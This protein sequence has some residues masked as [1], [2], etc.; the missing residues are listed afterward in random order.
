[1]NRCI[2]SLL[3]LTLAYAAL[4]AT[5]H[6]GNISAEIYATAQ[7]SLGDITN[8]HLDVPTVPIPSN[9]SGIPNSISFTGGSVVSSYEMRASIEQDFFDPVI[10]FVATAEGE[11]FPGG[12]NAGSLGMSSGVH[13]Q[14]MFDTPTA[15]GTK[16]ITLVSGTG[17]WAARSRRTEQVLNNVT[18]AQTTVGF[19]GILNDIRATPFTPEEWTGVVLFAIDALPGETPGNSAKMR[20]DPRFAD[21]QFVLPSDLAVEFL[22]LEIGP[23]GTILPTLDS[24]GVDSAIFVTSNFD[25]GA[26]VQS[27]RLGPAALTAG[28][29]DQEGLY[30]IDINQNS[31]SSLLLANPVGGLSSLSLSYVDHNGNLLTDTLHVGT[32]FQFSSADQIQSAYLHG[33]YGSESALQA[34][35]EE[36]NLG[37]QFANDGVAEV[38]AGAFARDVSSP[39]AVPEP[40]TF[41]LLGIGGLVLVGYGRRQ[42]RNR[43]RMKSGVAN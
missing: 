42:Q 34:I 40:S 38:Y 16:L 19:E 41:A 13:V 25:D 21:H 23:A 36:I 4:T 15:A 1:M 22:E 26:A 37:L 12:G 3:T 9:P 11:Y 17:Q 6:A 27:L 5:A 7:P 30:A 28:G 32:P 24:Y 8:R 33:F 10:R 43:A 18:F 31:L 39:T 14:Y 20:A 35:M 29:L 2:P